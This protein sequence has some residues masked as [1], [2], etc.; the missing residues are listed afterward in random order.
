MHASPVTKLK[1]GLI[2]C[3]LLFIAGAAFAQMPAK[4]KG[5]SRD[6]PYY[7]GPGQTR[8]SPLKQITRENVNQLQLAWTFDTNESSSY[9]SETQPI[10]VNGIFYGITPSHK[11]VALN[12]ATGKQLWKFDSGI[13]GRGPNRGLTYWTDGKEERVFI[14]NGTY[15]YAI[16]ARSGKAAASFGDAGRIDL[17]EGL[18]R[19][20]EK[21]SLGLST[22]GVVYRDLLIIG[23][24]MAETRGSPPGDIRAFD[25]RTGK[26]RWS[27][28]TIPHPGEFGYDTWPE[29]AWSYAGSAN[30]WA[31]MALDEKRGLVYVP[32]GSASSDFYGF[33]RHGDNLFANSL[34]ALKA[35]TGERVWHFQAVKHDIWDRD[36]DSPP[37][38]VTVKQNGKM[39]DAVAQTSKQ[40]W[41]YLFDRTSGKPLFPIEYRG[42]PA[43]TVPGEQAAATQGLPTKPAPLSRQRLTEDMLTNRTPEAHKWAVEKFRTLRSDGQFLPFA[44]GQDTVLMPGFDGGA[45]WGGSAFDPESGLI[46]VNA[47]DVAWWSRLVE[48]KGGGSSGQ[49][50]LAN[51]AACHRDDMTGAAGSIPSLMDLRGKRTADEIASVIQQGGARMPAFPNLSSTQR[52]AIAEYVLGGPDKELGGQETPPNVMPYRFTG[53][54]KFLDPDGYPAIVPPWGTLNA[55]DLNTGEYAWKIP[56]GEYPEF[57]E[58]GIKDTGTENYGGPIVTAGGLVFIGATNFD[59]KFRAFDKKTG[60]LLWETVLPQSGN[61]TPITYEVGGRQYV[62]IYAA[63]HARG[64]MDSRLRLHGAATVQPAS[65]TYVAF[66]LPKRP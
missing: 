62:V 7:G 24:R 15:L 9:A 60:K 3:L 37:T 55:I 12:A 32:T 52:S 10:M 25:V 53:Y 19:E 18:G 49:L 58:K 20:P 30:N 26:V 14:G 6:W 51:C 8:Y 57:A 41:L 17:R 36:F 11:L 33:D 2:P 63:T 47:N 65:A 48:N 54:N 27:F 23:G 21:L 31:G 1:S 22:P 28:H 43:S 40:G 66:T 39:V 42:Y 64:V 16:D 13:E 35:D 59:K 45:E 34:I 46:Y 29:D 38:L 50:Y 56:L 4:A 5:K 61:A 44:L